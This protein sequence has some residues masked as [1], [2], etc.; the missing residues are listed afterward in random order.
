MSSIGTS[1]ALDSAFL[2]SASIG[3]VAFA[4]LCLEL[5]GSR[6][7]LLSLVDNT[8]VEPNTLPRATDIISRLLGTASPEPARPIELGDAPLL[9]LRRAL[10]TLSGLNPA[11]AFLPAP[12][13]DPV[14][15]EPDP[16]DPLG[17]DE[18]LAGHTGGTPDPATPVYELMLAT[19]EKLAAAT[20]RSRHRLACMSAI[21]A[22]TADEWTRGAPIGALL[23]GSQQLD[24]ATGEV[25]KLLVEIAR[26][27]QGRS[28][29]P[30]G[31]FNGLQRA[32]RSLDHARLAAVD[33]LARAAVGVLPGVPTL[34]L[35]LHSV[36]ADALES[37]WADGRP[38][39][40]AAWIRTQPPGV[41]RSVALALTE[42]YGRAEPN[43]TASTMEAAAQAADMAG[44]PHLANVARSVAGAASLWTS[45]EER[46]LLLADELMASGRARH[47]GIVFADGALL[48]MEVHMSSGRPADARAVHLRA[49]GELYHMAAAGALQLLARWHPPAAIH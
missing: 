30:R 3:N 42:T 22:E 45:D 41:E 37:A 29:P 13:T 6:P 11:Q 49:G 16:D 35:D 36:P 10:I 4:D 7:R 15:P 14:P 31:L 32:A 47:N 2:R 33:H 38:M 8:E 23:H 18:I 5:F 28:V 48:A 25:L 1:L 34:G 46:S 9:T 24:A 19:A 26:A 27:A 39:D 20:A 17:L 40:S 44:R 43:D 12:P 21:I